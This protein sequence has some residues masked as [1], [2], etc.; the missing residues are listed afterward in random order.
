[1]LVINNNYDSLQVYYPIIAKPDTDDELD[2]IDG[3]V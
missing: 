3:S 2:D 1:M